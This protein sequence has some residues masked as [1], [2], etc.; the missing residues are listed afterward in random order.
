MG[1]VANQLRHEMHQKQVQVR[2]GLA[3]GSLSA[4]WF[5]TIAVTSFLWKRPVALTY[6][7]SAFLSL[8]LFG[9]WLFLPFLVSLVLGGF[10][11]YDAATTGTRV[12]RA[13]RRIRSRRTR[14]ILTRSW[15]NAAKD[16]GL[17]TVV[18]RRGQRIVVVPN[19]IQIQERN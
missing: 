14:I 18:D 19:L 12:L 4:L 9:S 11:I 3:K 13:R 15:P 2:Y 6:V 5:G 17:T 16:L 10:L 7:I 8:I 1:V